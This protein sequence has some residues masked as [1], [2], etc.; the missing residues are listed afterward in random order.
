MGLQ[1]KIWKGEK[2]LLIWTTWYWSGCRGKHHWNLKMLL[3]V[4]WIIIW[5]NHISKW[6]IVSYVNLSLC[7]CLS[8]YL[9]L[10]V[11]LS[12]D[13]KCFC[14]INRFFNKF[15]IC[16][17]FM[18]LFFLSFFSRRLR[19]ENTR[20]LEESN[21]LRKE[22]QDYVAETCK[23]TESSS[24]GRVFFSLWRTFWR[25]CSPPFL[26]SLFAVMATSIVP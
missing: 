20:L 6:F 19:E 26:L 3:Y 14:H 18:L 11:S 17:V 8:L 12:H 24:K 22:N 13:Q 21:R 2:H 25:W 4:Q 23:E 5:K 1:K 16:S 15:E 7:V 9:F 10:S